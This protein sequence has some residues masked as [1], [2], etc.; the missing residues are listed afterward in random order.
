MEQR[1]KKKQWSIVFEQKEDEDNHVTPFI[2]M[3][4]PE[5][6][7]NLK[8]PDEVVIPLSVIQIQYDFPLKEPVL[9]SFQSQEPTGFTRI[10]LAQKVEGLSTHLS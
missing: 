4:D 8:N 3:D 5:D 6:I 7:G 9:F 1:V 10:E 2:C